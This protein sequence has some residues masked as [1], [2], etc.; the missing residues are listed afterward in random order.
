M[1]E[2]LA[3]QYFLVRNFISAK[4]IYESILEKDPANKS[5]KKKLTIC[6]ITTGEIDKALTLF[7]SL[8]KDDIDFVINTDVHSEDCPCPDLISQIENEEKLF[9]NEIEKTTALGML[10]LY[11]NIENSIE[12]FKKAEMKSPSDNRIK[13]INSI[14]IK[15]LVSNKQNSIN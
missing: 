15:K 8:I 5:I 6:Y 2:M 13:E 12:L 10:W 7:L 1:S 3:N 4:S 11:C 14:L 9:K